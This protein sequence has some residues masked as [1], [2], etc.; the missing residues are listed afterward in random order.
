M[1]RVTINGK[2]YETDSGN[3]VVQNGKV[4]INGKDVSGEQYGETLT[5]K[6]EGDLASLRVDNGN[7]QCNDVNGNVDSGGSVTANN[8]TGNVSAGGSVHAT[9][10]EGDAS[11]GGSVRAGTIKG[12]A[13]AGG[14]MHIDGITINA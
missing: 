13:D 9:T 11:A 7:V 5:I 3:I 14:S 4:T 2:T 1:N 8:I 6:F 10:I 12:Q